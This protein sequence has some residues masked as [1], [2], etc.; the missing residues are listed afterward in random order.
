VEIGLAFH[1]VAVAP[2]ESIYHP[3]HLNREKAFT[4]R[5][6]KG[7]SKVEDGY[8]R[9]IRKCQKVMSHK[10]QRLKACRLHARD[11]PCRNQVRKKV[12]HIIIFLYSIGFNNVINNVYLFATA[13]QSSSLSW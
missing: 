4:C 5:K 1:K 6:Q 3:I 8:C 11:Y 7:H 13:N 10:S 2:S 9:R 12:F